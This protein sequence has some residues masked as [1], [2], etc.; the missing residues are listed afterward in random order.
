MHGHTDGQRHDGQQTKCDHKSS[1]CNYVT[2]ELKI[3]KISSICFLLNLPREHAKFNIRKKLLQLKSSNLYFSQKVGFDISCNYFLGKIRKP[4]LN[5]LCWKLYSACKALKLSCAKIFKMPVQYDWNIV[6][7]AITFYFIYLQMFELPIYSIFFN[8]V[9]GV[10][11][12]Y[13][14]KL[15]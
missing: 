8:K 14:L 10:S 3:R 5:V 4:F 1:P 12:L 2:D 9:G 11:S 15:T 13:I 7:R 6:E